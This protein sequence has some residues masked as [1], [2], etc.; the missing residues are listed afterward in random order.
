MRVKEYSNQD[1]W[2]SRFSAE[3]R[4][5]WL[6]TW[7][8]CGKALSAIL[9]GNPLGKNARILVVG[10]GNS[11]LGANLYDAGYKNTVNVD[12]SQVVIDAAK[13]KNKSRPEMEWLQQDCRD[14]NQLES[15]SLVL[16]VPNPHFLLIPPFS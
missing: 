7:D 10:C 5:E 11:E 14:M 15:Q 1:Y 2:D 9:D 12:F 3:Q 6:Q 13:E 4:F 16:F 8:S